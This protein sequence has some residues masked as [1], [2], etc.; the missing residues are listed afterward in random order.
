MNPVNH[1]I[2]HADVSTYQVEPYVVA[3]DVYSVPPHTGRGG[4]TWYTG[5][6]SWLY[7]AAIEFILG[8]QLRENS[9]CFDPQIPDAWNKFELRLRRGT[10]QWTF[11]VVRPDRDGSKH[12]GP[13]PATVHTGDQIILD[14][15]NPLTEVVI[16]SQSDRSSGL[17]DEELA[18]GHNVKPSTNNSNHGSSLHEALNEIA[19]Q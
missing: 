19:V 11:Q 15:A 12:S 5:S 7:R 3:A 13:S 9:V 6:A 1:A 8:F 14:T 4:W 17:S 10:K 16:G 2:T 18:Q